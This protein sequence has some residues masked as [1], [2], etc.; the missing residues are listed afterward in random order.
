MMGNYLTFNFGESYFRDR[1]VVSLIVEKMPVSISLG[2]WLLIIQYA[3]SIPLGIRKAV[4]DG[5]PFDIWTS[6]VIIIG[7]AIPSF[8]FAIMLIVR[9]R[10][11]QLFQL[12]SLA[13]PDIRQFRAAELPRQGN[14]LCL[15]SGAAADRHGHR[16]LRHHDASHQELL[17]RR[18]PQAVCHDGAGQG[19]DRAPGA[20]RP[21]LPQCHAAGDFRLS[22]RLSRRLLRRIAAHRDRLLAR[23]AGLSH[24][25]GRARPRLSDRLRQALHL[26]AGGTRRGAD[27]ATSSI[28]GSIRASTSNGGTSRPWRCSS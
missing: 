7:Y 17:P 23:R 9:L 21:C 5:T 11:R 20:L 16:R 26:H 18:D 27:L 1:S 15:A 24:L 14:G 28:P 10:R 3:V 22:G 8:I 6:G 2:L 25:Q 19:P 4:K 13:R 12:V